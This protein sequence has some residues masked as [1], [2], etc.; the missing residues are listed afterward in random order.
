MEEY[1]AVGCIWIVTKGERIFSDMPVG[2]SALNKVGVDIIDE[3][4]ISLRCQE[5]EGAWSP[6]IQPGGELLKG[7]WVCPYQKCNK[8]E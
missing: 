2:E 1:H 3:D 4:R 7:Y 6:M 8:P 5:C